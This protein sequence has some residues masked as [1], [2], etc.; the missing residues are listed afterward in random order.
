M[1][2]LAPIVS[3]PLVANLVEDSQVYWI[4]AV[5]NVYDPDTFGVRST[6]IPALPAGITYNFEFDAFVIDMLDPVWQGLGAGD[7][8]QIR[9]DYF[10]TDGENVVPHALI[11]NVTGVNDGAVL[12]GISAGAVVEDA[13]TV[14]EGQL[15][16]SDPDQG[17]SA[18]VVT[19]TPIQGA[20]GNLTITADGHWTY[21]LDNNSAAVQALNDGDQMAEVFTVQTIDGTAAQISVT[22]DGQSERLISGTAG[23]DVLSGTDLGEYFFG[24]GGSDRISGNGGSDTIDGGTGAD[25][26][27]GGLG[28]DVILFDAG[29]RVQDGGAGID[30]LNVGRS[31]TINLGATDQVSGDSGT[32]TGFEHVDGTYATAAL[33]LTGSAGDNILAGG[34]AGDRL[35]SGLGIDVLVG[36]GGADRFIYRS[37]A[38]AVGDEIAD[39]THGS[40]RID[41][42][43]IDAIAGGRDNAFSFIG[44]A[45][46]SRAG[47]LRYDAATGQVLGDTNGDRV[48]DLVIDIGAG[49]V[50][51]ASDFLL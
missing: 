25:S 13:V 18:F 12:S 50:I 14:T 15:F 17:E 51:T 1:A 43:A 41:L 31:A 37:T 45:A 5:W 46:F 34:S 32:T 3:G 33:V 16:V 10:V 35:T 8:T 7:Q 40:D 24:L 44:G 2:N 11:L 22:I 36:N 47:Q 4:A 42:S 49:L 30:T 19:G 39:F 29:D 27:Y 9:I 6:G 26:L 48:A 20:F 21:V 38:E 23:S 28:D